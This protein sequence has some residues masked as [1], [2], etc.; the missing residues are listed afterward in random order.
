[1]EKGKLKI[2]FGYCAGVGKTYTML[3]DAHELLKERVDVII[4]YIEPHDRKDTTA[5]T[6]GLEVLPLKKIEYKGI[7]LH[8]F[9]VDAAIKRN[10]QVILIDELAHTNAITSHN[11]KR[12]QDII[13]LLNHGINVWTTLNVQHLDGLN[14]SLRNTLGVDVKET[15]PDSVFDQANEVK[16]IDIEP[17]DLFERFKE[18]KI[19]GKKVINVALQNFF[20]YD[21]LFALRELCLRRS[22]DR[23]T[24]LQNNG[25][26]T[27][28][29][30]VLIS[31]SPSSCNLIRVASRMAINNKTTFTALYISKNNELNEEDE[32]N[33]S[34]NIKLAKDLEGQVTIKYSTDIIEAL[35]SFVTL[36]KVTSIIIGKS[37]KSMFHRNNLEDKIVMAFSNIE[38]LIVPNGSKYLS[39][40]K[41]SQFKKIYRNV[42]LIL[43]IVLLLVSIIVT[44]F[45]QFSGLITSLVS[46]GIVTLC[47]GYFYLKNI[48]YKKR[49]QTNV[50]MID[51]YDYILHEVQHA[52]G[53]EKY[54][55]IAKCLSNI[56]KTSVYFDANKNV[57][58]VKYSEDDVSAFDGSKEDAIR[59]WVMINN[60]EAGNGCDSLNDGNAIYF[61]ISKEHKIIGIVG[62]LCINRS[63]NI[64][65][66]LLFYKIR[67][68]L[69][70][71]V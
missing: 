68:L 9:D 64:Q 45:N 7:T 2:Y 52:Y 8:E 58:K 15:V 70:N 61:P 22:A 33:L 25:I 19:Y 27:S 5:L 63:F 62:F 59:A 23:L 11:K 17:A 65:N 41:I 42:I 35:Y 51:C 30:L 21:H 56:F 34:K 36:N 47:A 31:P 66:K 43:G 53:D 13:E 6:D 49:I 16:I 46:L 26:A 20:T 50:K 69:R 18:G 54:I 71:I 37:W 24:M 29:I 32:K 44:I 67:S 60:T 3:K 4:G 40:L 57:V 38:I 14:D 12:Y 28:K 1:M 48:Q 55:R 39:P 10:P